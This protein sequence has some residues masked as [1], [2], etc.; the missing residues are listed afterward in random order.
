MR[1]ALRKVGGLSDKHGPDKLTPLIKMTDMKIKYI[2]RS[3]DALAVRLLLVDIYM[4]DN[5]EIKKLSEV[6]VAINNFINMKENE[7]LNQEV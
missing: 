6:I 5:C 4:R 1:L 7:R 2:L 3:P